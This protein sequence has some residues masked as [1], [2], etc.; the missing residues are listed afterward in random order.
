MNNKLLGYQPMTYKEQKELIDYTYQSAGRN[1]FSIC[2]LSNPLFI[3]TLWSYLYKTYGE[4]KYGYLPYW[5]GQKQYLNKS[6][7]DYDTNHVQTR[8]L[9]IEP[10]VG[11]NEF[12]RK[13][14]I[15]SEDEVSVI[16][17]T[18]Q[19]GQIIIQKRRLEKNNN[20][21]Q[22]SQNLS[23][24]D[25]LSMKKLQKTDPRYSCFVYY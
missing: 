22:D 17:E 13:A 4:K 23:P 19:F 11:I 15:Y 21:L 24:E 12:S 9:I 3:N 25:S 18:K 5:A 6:F 8:F 7:F 1:K 20:L 2:S 16:E 10:M 14:T